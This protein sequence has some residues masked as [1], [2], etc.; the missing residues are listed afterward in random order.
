M[1]I[2]VVGAQETGWVLTKHTSLRGEAGDDTRGVDAGVYNKFVR[3]TGVDDTGMQAVPSGLRWRS[4]ERTT[5]GGRPQSDL[6][7]LARAQ[8]AGR[9]VSSSVGGATFAKE[10]ISS[11]GS[12]ISSTADN[13]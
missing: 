13:Q 11:R 12:R 7:S 9:H 3:D 10:G 5:G 4:S 1:A 6:I 8:R 2:H